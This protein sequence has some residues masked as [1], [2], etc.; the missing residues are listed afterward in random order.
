MPIEPRVI[1]R[2]EGGIVYDVK[3]TVPLNVSIMYEDCSDEDEER[4]RDELE[5]EFDLL[6][7]YVV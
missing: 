2:V 7:M 6:P 3:S 1:I 4:E 5:K